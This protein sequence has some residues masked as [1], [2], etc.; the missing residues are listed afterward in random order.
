MFKNA[1]QTLKR[2]HLKSPKKI[3]IVFTVQSDECEDGVD[4]FM[5]P[6]GCYDNA[7]IAAVVM[8]KVSRREP[9]KG[10]DYR[11]LN[12]FEDAVVISLPL[13]STIRHD[14]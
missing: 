9:I 1:K 12:D 5:D 6:I 11:L 8:G 14:Q 13:N 3:H 7:G 4:H 2:I 10:I